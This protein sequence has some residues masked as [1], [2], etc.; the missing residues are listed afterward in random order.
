MPIG[1]PLSLTPNI[2]R[3]VVT[4]TASG[5]TT[6]FTVT[7]GYRVGQLG[8]YL[9]GVRLVDA[10]D[11]TARDGSTVGLTTAAADGD[12]ISFQIFDSF[13]ISDAIM[14]NASDQ[15][16]N[17]SLTVNDT[18][19]VGGKLT[20]SGIGSFTDVVSS[21]IVTADS[22]YGDG[23][24]LDGVG[25]GGIGTAINYSDGKTASP[26]N[27]FDDYVAITENMMLDTSSAGMSTS[28]IVSVIPNIRIPAGIAVT[29]GAGKTMIIDVL[30]VGDG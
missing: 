7:G 14:A 24:N 12:T 2:A 29:I 30:N 23:S 6:N 13:N 20:V 18:T 1:R 15:T 8:V 27:Y 10:T 3:K 26:F 9:N 21:G 4:S 28:Y 19:T 16:I 17:G 5:V 22:F 25:G 11:Y